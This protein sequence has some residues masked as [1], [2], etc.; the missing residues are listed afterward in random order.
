VRIILPYF[1]LVADIPRQ[2][3]AVDVKEQLQWHS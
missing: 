1:F 2:V 3:D